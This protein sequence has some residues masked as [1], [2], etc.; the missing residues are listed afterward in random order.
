MNACIQFDGN[1]SESF[2]VRSGVKHGWVLAPTL[3]A[4]YFAA[5]FQHAFDGKEDG[6]YRRTRFNGS[7]FNLKRLKSKRLTTEVL[8]RGLLFADDAAIATHSE[9]ELQRLAGR[10]AEACDLFGLSISTKKTGVTGQG[11]NSQQVNL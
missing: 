6:L 11:T 1:T 3:F 5:L 10:L 4:I 8:I 2:K 7:L 9:I